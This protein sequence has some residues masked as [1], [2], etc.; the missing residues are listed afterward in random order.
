MGRNGRSRKIRKRV[1]ISV[2]LHRNLCLNG[3][4]CASVCVC[5]CVCVC[6]NFT[7]QIRSVHPPLR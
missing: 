7:S 1:C 4:E 2:S 3:L 5:V 6:A